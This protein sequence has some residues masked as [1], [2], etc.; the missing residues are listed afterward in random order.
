MEFRQL[1][2]FCEVARTLSF[3]R[4]AT[5]LGYV[6]SNVTAQIQSLEAELGVPLFD[7]IGKRVHLT[8]AGSA[9]LVHAEKMLRLT[10]EARQSVQ[11]TDEINGTV[12]I[13]ASE[14]ICTYRL[15]GLMKR[16]IETY[17]HARL[18]FRPSTTATLTRKETL[19]SELDVV[20]IIDNSIPPISVVAEI[21]GYEQIV[22]VS[23]PHHPLA[24]FTHLTAADLSSETLLCVERPC[25]YA[26]LFENI[27]ASQQVI[28]PG[29]LEFNSIEAMKQCIMARMGFSCLPRVTIEK[30]LAD[31]RLVQLPWPDATNPNPYLPVTMTRHRDRWVSP[32]LNAFLSMAREH[33]ETMFPIPAASQSV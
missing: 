33:F 20:F 5:T 1:T 11:R 27:L 6:Q 26:T 30:E 32:T 4:A 7:R 23:A 3:T 16:F 18:I 13:S 19:E 17:P 29:D 15:P 10:E 25:C 8:S 24:Q 12:T 14:T 22:L 2:T 21:M 9:F 31:G 28:L